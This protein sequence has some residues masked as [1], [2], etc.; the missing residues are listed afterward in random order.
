MVERYVVLLSVTGMKCFIYLRARRFNS[1]VGKLLV[2]HYSNLPIV[3]E[4]E[5]EENHS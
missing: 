3:P 5:S 4:R 2:S 1:M